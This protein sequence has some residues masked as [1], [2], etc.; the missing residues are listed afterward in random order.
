[1]PTNIML[2]GVYFFLCL[3]ECR[4][5]SPLL[6]VIIINL[7]VLYSLIFIERESETPDQMCKVSYSDL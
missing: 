5:L 3:H 4:S 2:S 6:T 7:A 1:M